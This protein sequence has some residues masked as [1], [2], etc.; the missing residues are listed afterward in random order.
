MR[1]DQSTTDR[2]PAISERPIWRAIRRYVESLKQ[3]VD[4]EIRGYPSPIA[5][6]DAQFNYLLEERAK[7][8]R[9]LGRL[10]ALAQKA[11]SNVSPDAAVE[12]FLRETDALDD[13]AEKSLREAIA[14]EFRDRR[15]KAGRAH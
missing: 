8:S 15:A 6:C 5:G 10:D 4:A 3:P 1:P 14:E 11:A 12:A 7:L 13:E 9:A 2:E